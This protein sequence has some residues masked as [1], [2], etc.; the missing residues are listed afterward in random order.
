M[1]MD[2]EEIQDQRGLHLLSLDGGGIRGVSELI[3]LEEIMF[4]IQNELGLGEIPRPYEYF[5][6]IGGT[7]TG[8]FVCA[9]PAH[10]ISSTTLFRTYKVPRMVERCKIWQA[11][12][13]TTAAPTIFKAVRIGSANAEVSYIDAALSCNNPVRHVLNEAKIVFK[14]RKVRSILSIGTGQSFQIG[15]QETHAFQ[16]GLDISTV[17]KSM[18]TDATR[19]AKEMEHEFINTQDIYFR[20]S[21]E[22]GLQNITTDEWKRVGEVKMCTRQYLGEAVISKRIDAVVRALINKDYYEKIRADPP[23]KVYKAPVSTIGVG[24]MCELQGSVVEPQPPEIQEMDS[25]CMDHPALR[26]PPSESDRMEMKE[27]NKEYLPEK[28]EKSEHPLDRKEKLD[29]IKEAAS[30]IEDPDDEPPCYS[31][32]SN[33]SGMDSVSTTF[34]NMIMTGIIPPSVQESP[35]ESS[36]DKV[37]EEP[38]SIVPTNKS[39]AESL[40]NEAVQSPEPRSISRL[41]ATSRD[42]SS[43]RTSSRTQS[44]FSFIFGGSRNSKLPPAPVGGTPIDNPSFEATTPKSKP[45]PKNKP[46]V[47]AMFAPTA[48]AAP[49]IIE[50]KMTTPKPITS[51]S[52]VSVSPSIEAP[53]SRRNSRESTSSRFL[54]LNALSRPTTSTSFTPFEN[55]KLAPPAPSFFTNPLCAPTSFPH[56]SPT[57][58]TFPLPSLT[59]PGSPLTSQAI[60][61]SPITSQSLFNSRLELSAL[62]DCDPVPESLA[63]FSPTSNPTPA[64]LSPSPISRPSSSHLPSHLPSHPTMHP[65]TRPMSP[66]MSPPLPSG[67][68]P[69]ITSRLSPITSIFPSTVSTNLLAPPPIPNHPTHPSSPILDSPTDHLSSGMFADPISSL[70]ATYAYLRNMFGAEHTHTL[71]SMVRLAIS[72]RDGKQNLEEA[73]SMLSFVLSIRQRDLGPENSETLNAKDQL[74]MVY[75][76]Q[77]KFDEAVELIEPSIE[78]RKR[79]IKEKEDIKRMI[80]EKEYEERD[81]K[82]SLSSVPLSKKEE[83][84]KERQE[85]ERQ[86]FEQSIVEWTLDMVQEKCLLASIYDQNERYEEAEEIAKEVVDVRSK[87]LGEGHED[88]VD[89]VCVLARILGHRG[90]DEEAESMFKVAFVGGRGM[91]NGT[92]GWANMHAYAA[93]LGRL[94]KWE[95]AAELLREVVRGERK[96]LGEEHPDFR[97]SVKMLEERC[98]EIGRDELE[99]SAKFAAS[100]VLFLSSDSSLLSSV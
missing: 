45:K 84:A 64:F 66:P 80:E 54:S 51:P 37:T 99:F 79:I 38:L 41:S 30:P 10:D 57:Q 8:G 68:P 97:W 96:A 25:G 23:R 71:S 49:M 13:A 26:L 91:G 17:L 29:A 4:R 63:P 46:R 44:R 89:A 48:F 1:D 18:A 32:P 40:R 19:V 60:D 85:K 7:S 14:D 73:A 67:S 35:K 27:K 86:E 88:S 58:H 5:D 6:L 52:M 24:G 94:G 87:M 83:E 56:P 81:K 22:Q 43:S 42:R 28:S 16:R 93:V 70:H 33:E 47:S 72:H 31:E 50:P 39:W 15:I 20:F 69:L 59:P 21:V 9:V 53:S 36:I 76:Y 92:K 55:Q 95:E 77:R 98:G 78:I 90:R 61:N 12:R 62:E 74:A 100:F 2:M 11:A 75:N 65:T 34:E 82:Q 3:I